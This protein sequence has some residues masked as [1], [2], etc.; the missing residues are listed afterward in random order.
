[1]I[2]MSALFNGFFL[3]MNVESQKFLKLDTLGKV[4]KILHSGA[5]NI[6]K[7]QNYL[8]P[9]WRY[10][11]ISAKILHSGAFHIIKIH[12]FLQPDPSFWC[13]SEHQNPKIFFN[14]GEAA[15]IF[16]W[17]AFQVIEINQVESIL[18]WATQILNSCAFQIIEI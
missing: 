15:Q 14:H 2:E 8:Q 10:S 17:C 16:H 6:I 7:M 5:F 11:E 3:L 4:I 13:I 1:M 18:R 9:W 12:N